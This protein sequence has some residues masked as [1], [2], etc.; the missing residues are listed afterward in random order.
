[1][2]ANKVTE[3]AN[4]VKKA[5]YYNVPL[6]DIFVITMFPYM[7]YLLSQCTSIQYLSNDLLARHHDVSLNSIYFQISIY[8]WQHT[9]IQIH[10]KL[11]GK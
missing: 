6:Y 4:T 11:I 7:I 10:G 2:S 8:T 9:S 1:M 5:C 3:E